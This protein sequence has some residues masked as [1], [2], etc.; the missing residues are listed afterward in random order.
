MILS[1]QSWLFWILSHLLLFF[2]VSPVYVLQNISYFVWFWTLFME[3]VRFLQDFAS[4][5]IAFGIHRKAGSYSYFIHVLSHLS[6]VQLFAT[7]WTVTHQASLSMGFFRQEYWSGLPFP[8]PGDPIQGLNPSL[9]C[10]LCWQEGPLP[11]VPPI[12]LFNIP[13]LSILLKFG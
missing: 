3:L 2:F 10:L 13:H 12:P 9:L 4:L 11:P 6:R 1:F 5:T 8:S 7:P